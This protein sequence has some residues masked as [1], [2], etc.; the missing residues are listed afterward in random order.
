MNRIHLLIA[1]YYRREARLLSMKS[2]VRMLATVMPYK[3]ITIKFAIYDICP[4]L[5]HVLLYVLMVQ[6]LHVRNA[7]M[8]SLRLSTHS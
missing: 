3:R 2:Y 1:V 5:S 8:T 7:I 6:T 4:T